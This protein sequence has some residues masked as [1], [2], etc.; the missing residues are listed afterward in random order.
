M[1]FRE[2]ERTT[3][4]YWAGGRR[5][6]AANAVHARHADG[7]QPCRTVKS[8]AAKQLPKSHDHGVH[9]QSLPSGRA[10]RLPELLRRRCLVVAVGCHSI[11]NA[12][13]RAGE[14]PRDYI[15]QQGWCGRQHRASRQQQGHVLAP[16]SRLGRGGE[17]RSRTNATSSCRAQGNSP[18]AT[19]LPLDRSRYASGSAVIRDLGTVFGVKLSSRCR[20]VRFRCNRK[21]L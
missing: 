16:G 4:V 15:R 19:R 10:G 9:W 11:G 18:F 8:S 21:A 3:G 5:R 7:T 6:R 20:G 14:R 13:K 2:T 17:L 1:S 12:S